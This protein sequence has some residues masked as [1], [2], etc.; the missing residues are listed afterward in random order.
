MTRRFRLHS[1]FRGADKIKE[2]PISIG[3]SNRN[4]VVLLYLALYLHDLSN[5]VRGS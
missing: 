5:L 4:T 1:N 3:F 2:L